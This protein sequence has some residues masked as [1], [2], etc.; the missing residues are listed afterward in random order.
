VRGAETDRPTAARAQVMTTHGDLDALV[1]PHRYASC[2]RAPT[3]INSTSA[4][5]GWSISGQPRLSY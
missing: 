5:G 1:S 3:A 4:L 2:R